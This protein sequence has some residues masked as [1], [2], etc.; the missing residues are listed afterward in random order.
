MR[1][2]RLAR[3]HFGS[4]GGPARP[5]TVLELRL[6]SSVPE[7]AAWR[8]TLAA[9]LG[10]PVEVLPKALS[11]A[12]PCGPGVG[13]P[14]AAPATSLHHTAL[15]MRRAH[16]AT[17]AAAPPSTAARD[18]PNSPPSGGSAGLARTLSARNLL[19][20]LDPGADP[21]AAGVAAPALEM[22]LP[23]R[24]ERVRGLLV[25]LLREFA[26]CHGPLLVVLDDTHLFDGGSWRLLVN[27]V[28]SL[29][30]VNRISQFASTAELYAT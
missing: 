1:Q 24:A 29:S 15:P 20:P 9:A 4:D 13:L 26:A 22:S 27:I 18:Q 6:R 3:H 11:G 17:A 28:E 30:Q 5:P 2:A 25:A 16:S 14:T 10:L 7:Y 21:A 12:Q 8:P 23:L 19:V